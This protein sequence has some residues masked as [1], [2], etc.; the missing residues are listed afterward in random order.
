MSDI[1]LS[2]ICFFKSCRN[3]AKKFIKKSDILLFADGNTRDHSSG[4]GKRDVREIESPIVSKTRER[5][6]LSNAAT[7]SPV[8][9]E[10]YL[11]GRLTPGGRSGRYAIPQTPQNFERLVLVLGYIDTDF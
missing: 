6:E 2:E 9:P 10:R 4:A 1:I 8:R 5:V 11:L 3:F 7:S